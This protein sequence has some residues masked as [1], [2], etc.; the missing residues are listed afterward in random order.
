MS[1][2]FFQPFVGKD[3]A[4]GGIFGKRVMVLGESHYCDEGCVDCGNCSR[5]RECMGFTQNVVQTYLEQDGGH[6]N[7]MNTF[8]KFE[9]SLVGH[10]TDQKETEKIWNSVI[11]FNYLQVAMGGPREAGTA[12]QY[13]QAGLAFFEMLEKFLPEYVV[14][15]GKRLW[16]NLPGD[17][18]QDGEDVVVD[19]Y[20]TATGSYVLRG[21]KR[22]KVMAVN[23]PSVGYSWDYWHRVI[24]DFCL[25]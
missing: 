10:E 15:W 19:G 20:A 4:N 16:N 13:R 1:N 25:M 14:V 23:H 22:V 24:Q 6:E 12:D 11:F 2:V 8:L 18:W 9:R 3:Y 21:G 17:Q 5:H 7:W